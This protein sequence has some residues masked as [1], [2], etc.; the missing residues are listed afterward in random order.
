M[1]CGCSDMFFRVLLCVWQCVCLVHERVMMELSQRD[2][3]SALV[4]ELTTSGEP[5]LNQNKMKEIKN[6]CKYVTKTED[7]SPL[8]TDNPG[9]SNCIMTC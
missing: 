6:I 4:E 1:L 7:N 8:H 2:R 5:Q 9:I 3:L